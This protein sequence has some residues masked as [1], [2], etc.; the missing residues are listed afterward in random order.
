MSGGCGKKY[1]QTSNLSFE[2]LI[3]VDIICHGTPNP[4][5]LKS[6]VA[7]VAG[8]E[9]VEKC[10]FRDANFDTSKFAYTLYKHASTDPFIRNTLMKMIFIKLVIMV[11]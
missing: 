9:K 4:D 1:F 11:R 2:K 5:Y 6:H 8:G 7:A 3:L 10:F